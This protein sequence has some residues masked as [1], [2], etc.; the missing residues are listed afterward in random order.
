MRRLGQVFTN[1]SAGATAIDLTRDIGGTGVPFDGALRG[2]V[3]PFLK[4]VAGNVGLSGQ[5]GLDQTCPSPS[6]T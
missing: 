5:V 1:V 6:C 2:A 4:A 3:G